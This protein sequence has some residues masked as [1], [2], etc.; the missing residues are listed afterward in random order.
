MNLLV[1]AGQQVA[2]F[3]GDR[4][5]LPSWDRLGRG[6][7][8]FEV[9]G[10]DRHSIEPLPQRLDGHVDTERA[11]DEG[12]QRVTHDVTFKRQLLSRRL[13]QC[14]TLVFPQPAK[15]WRA[16]KPPALRVA[17]CGQIVA[18]RREVPCHRERFPSRAPSRGARCCSQGRLVAGDQPVHRDRARLGDHR[19]I[20]RR[21]P[22]NARQRLG[23]LGGIQPNLGSE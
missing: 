21:E 14:G 15:L 7:N 4:E 5:T 8:E 10:R 3:V 20:H 13:G 1:V 2:E 11:F 23:E 17:Q 19:Q 18:D 22:T 12:S 6:Q 16:W 9:R